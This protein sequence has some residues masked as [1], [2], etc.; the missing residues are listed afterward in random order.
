MTKSDRSGSRPRVKPRIYVE[1]DWAET[2]IYTLVTKLLALDSK[3][4][5]SESKAM[6]ESFLNPEGHD[7]FTEEE[8]SYYSSLLRRQGSTD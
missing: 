2:P 5:I 6:L 1:T 3:D 7:I 8:A 4:K